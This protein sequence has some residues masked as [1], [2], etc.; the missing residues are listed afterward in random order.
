MSEEDVAPPTDQPA[1]LPPVQAGDSTA[2]R[3][4]YDPRAIARTI[5]GIVEDLNE[6]GK[7][8][9]QQYVALQ[10]C[11][12]DVFN[13]PM[14]GQDM[15]NEAQ[16]TVE[17]ALAMLDQSRRMMDAAHEERE[18]E[19]AVRAVALAE[20]REREQQALAREQQALERER[21][22]REREAQEHRLRRQR[23]HQEAERIA[24]ERLEVARRQLGELEAERACRW[25]AA[26]PCSKRK[27]TEPVKK[28]AQSSKTARRSH[29][30]QAVHEVHTDIVV[31]A[32]VDDGP[33]EEAGDSDSDDDFEAFLQQ[34]KVQRAVDSETAPV[35]ERPAHLDAW[36]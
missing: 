21:E 10:N 30:P 15:E 35:P 16:N 18:R 17:R 6:E 1:E 36:E 33:R 3:R 24:A 13:F 7:L 14:P 31:Y 34:H 9:N 12:R 23:E 19:R 26:K 28:A 11:A 32:E 2:R 22:R 8:D 27:E 29:V 20:A 5:N 25:E 4:R